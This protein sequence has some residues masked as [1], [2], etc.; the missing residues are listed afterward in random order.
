MSI[1][2]RDSFVARFSEDTAFKIEQASLFH[3][4]EDNP[5]DNI[6][7]NGG[8]GSDNWG[9]DP[10]RYHLLNCIGHECFEVDV[11]RTYHGFTQ[12]ES[13]VDIHAWVV[14]NADLSSFDGDH[15][16]HLSRVLGVYD[17]WV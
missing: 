15:P 14:A 1:S 6:L 9:S 17:G 4:V 10:F 13:L 11:Y 7:G 12:T 5:V 8:H 16:D 2:I 3:A